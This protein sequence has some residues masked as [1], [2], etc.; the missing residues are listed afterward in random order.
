MEEHKVILNRADILIADRKHWRRC[1]LITEELEC[2][3]SNV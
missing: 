2:E 3:A 1:A